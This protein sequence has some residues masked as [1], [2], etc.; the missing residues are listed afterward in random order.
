M[1]NKF[2]I[3]DFVKIRS[4]SIYHNQNKNSGQIVYIYPPS[5]HTYQVKFT[6]GYMN[7]YRPEDLKYTKISVIKL[8][9]RCF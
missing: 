8:N 2:K 7:S 6:D 5:E 3:G 4:D 9:K 1:V